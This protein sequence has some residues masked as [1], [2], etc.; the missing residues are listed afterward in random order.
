MQGA[1]YSHRLHYRWSH[2]EAEH[3]G[4]NM[5]SVARPMPTCDRELHLVGDQREMLKWPSAS[6]KFEAARFSACAGSYNTIDYNTFSKNGALKLTEV[7]MYFLNSMMTRETAKNWLLVYIGIG[8]GERF[9]HIRDQFYPELPVIAF[10][11]ID[12]FYAGDRSDVDKRAQVWNNDGTNYTFHLRCYD[13][14]NDP[15]M[16][17]EQAAGRGVLLISDVRGVNLCNDGKTFDKSS[18]NDLQWQA[19]QGIRPVRSMLKFAIPSA[20]SQF[21]EYAP[22]R[23]LKQT[24]CNYGTR[25]TRLLIEG[26]PQQKRIYNGWELY[27]QMQYHH[28]HLRGLVYET[29]RRPTCAKCFDFCF[30]C[31]V[32]CDTFSS[33][34][35]K[36]NLDPDKVLDDVVKYHVY[37]P[38]HDGW[39]DEINPNWDRWVAPSPEQRWNDVLWALKKGHLTEAVASLEAEGEADGDDVDWRAIADPL[40]PAQPHISRRL[41]LALQH[42]ASREDL[43]RVIGSLGQPFT[44][45]RDRKSVV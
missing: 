3:N 10:D 37:A 36:N 12:E 43:I 28:E 17:R 34:A 6:A 44:L 31:S 5:G 8:N 23:I 9:K 2:I 38:P 18:D 11:P 40:W 20:A 1:R 29:T 27:D 35:A 7:E 21:Y 32:L 25:E 30:D 4:H 42:N 16:I 45:V 19:I 39:F 14:D 13:V 41:R 26:V 33:Y 15:D 24:F 22:G